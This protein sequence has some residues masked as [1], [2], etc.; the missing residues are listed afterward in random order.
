MSG[1]ISSSPA[2]FRCSK[3]VCVAATF[4]CYEERGHTR[5]MSVKAI[6][7]LGVAGSIAAVPHLTATGTRIS[8]RPAFVRVV[9]DFNGRVSAKQVVFDRLWRYGAALHID[10]PG[11][12]MRTGGA[13]GKGVIVRLGPATQGLDIAVSSWARRFKYVSYTVVGGNRLAIDLWKS[14]LRFAG[15]NPIHTCAGLTLV[16]W[17][18]NGLTH[19]VVVGGREHGIFEN[20]FQVVVRGQHGGVVGRKLVH[21]PGRWRT[22]VRYHVAFTQPG[23]VEAVALSPK[24]GSLVCIAQ[25]G[26]NLPAT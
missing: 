16:G 19:T 2:C 5:G 22:R 13:D 15:N 12:G 4:G 9:V 1:S 8:D 11:I 10:R 6:A 17:S 23:S 24:D 18:S 3:V 26:I 25:L 7:L 14:T 21:G 20:Q